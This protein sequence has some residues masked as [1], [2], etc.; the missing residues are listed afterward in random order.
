MQFL[1]KKKKWGL[2]RVNQRE[3]VVNLEGLV[4]QTRKKRCVVLALKAVL[5]EGAVQLDGQARRGQGQLGRDS[6]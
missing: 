1:K 2:N 6:P 4:S 3:I 5:E